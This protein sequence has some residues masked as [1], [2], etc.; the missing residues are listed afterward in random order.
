MSQIH[1]VGRGTGT[2]K[3]KDEV[4]KRE[5]SECDGCVCDLESIGVP[6]I[7]NVI[8]SPGALVRMLPTLDLR[9]VGTLEVYY[10]KGSM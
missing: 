1:W 3:D 5:V 8:L 7:F 10:E 9:C 4:N 6:S 2:P